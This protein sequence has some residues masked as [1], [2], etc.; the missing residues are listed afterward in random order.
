MRLK[1]LALLSAI[2]FF[3][4]IASAQAGGL[5]IGVVGNMTTFN[6]SGTETEGDAASNGDVEQNTGSIE[7]DADFGSIFVEYAFGG[8]EA[9]AGM[10]FGVEH[11]PGTASLGART[12]SDSNSEGDTQ[13]IT[14]KAEISEYYS[15]YVEPTFY[16]NETWGAYAKLG[17]HNLTVNTLETGGNSSYG[18][19]RIWG[20]S[21]GVG[22]RGIH[23]SG[24]FA[25]VEY[26]DTEYQSVELE[27]ATGNKNK[28]EA[29]PTSESIR[30]AIGFQF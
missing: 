17:A 6:T 29:K 19:D 8:D 23:T 13:D 27:S 5:G 25:K 24:V 26:L 12:R 2:G 4:S 18:N 15:V 10:T 22:V 20:A 28:I 30:L 11:I 14:G 9:G 3:L 21:W 7:S 1:I 16:I